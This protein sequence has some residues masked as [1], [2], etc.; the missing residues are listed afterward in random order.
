MFSFKSL[1]LKQMGCVHCAP[2]ATRG[3][4]VPLQAH[5]SEAPHER[6]QGASVHGRVEKCALSKVYSECPFFFSFFLKIPCHHNL[7]I[8][9]P[10]L[11]VLS[12]PEKPAA[13][14]RPFVMS[15]K[16]LLPLP[17]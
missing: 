4:I 7:L 3:S 17:G 15:Q 9:F 16:A 14:S 6:L 10:S 2:A 13:G 1:N 11:T 12:V 8:Y 5:H